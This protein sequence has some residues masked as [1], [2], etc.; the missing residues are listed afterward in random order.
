MSEFWEAFHFADPA[1]GLSIFAL[2]LI[3]W[4]KKKLGQPVATVFFPNIA[5][6]KKYQNFRSKRWTGLP[7]LFRGLGLFF[8]ILALC[9]PQLDRSTTT[10]LASGID[11]VLAI[12][13][14][15]SMRKPDPSL[16]MDTSR[17]EVVVD[18]L[19]EF[20]KQRTYDR[21]GLV[22]FA[23]KPYLINPIDL[24]KETLLQ[25]LA[26]LQKIIVQEDAG[27]KLISGMGVAINQLRELQSQSKII[28]LLSDGKDSSN[29]YESPLVL[30]KL[31]HDEG[32]K[33][34]TIS[35][36][37]DKEGE[38]VD[39]ETLREIA[40]ITGAKHFEAENK[41]TLESI[42]KEI[43]LLEKSEVKVKVNSLFEDLYFWPLG[44]SI[45]FLFIEFIL[46]RTRYLRIP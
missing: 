8:L 19:Q 22:G 12:D 3:Y 13:L 36:G 32:I 44:T 5:Q 11:I 15:G 21:I 27:T 25:K 16:G 10:I 30:A 28:I 23:E 35:F 39:K 41:T 29:S 42:Y 7:R 46:S 33:I 24:D 45:L 18:V 4:I 9:R 17:L 37:S 38:T 31:S 2:P 6:L 43:D 34:Y 14:S 26:N 1:W 20:L 40:D